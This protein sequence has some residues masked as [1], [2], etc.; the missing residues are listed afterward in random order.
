VPGPP[1]PVYIDG[2]RME[3]QVAFGPMTGAAANLVVLSYCDTLNVGVNTDPAAIADP[4][5]FTECMREGFHEVLN[6]V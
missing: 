2:A 6:L 5:L 1:V 3:R 4:D